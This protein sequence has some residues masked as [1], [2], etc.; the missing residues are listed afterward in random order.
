MSG[1]HS[2]TN[3]S[4]STEIPWTTASCQSDSHSCACECRDD[5]TCVFYD[6]R[7]MTCVLYSSPFSNFSSII[8]DASETGNEEGIMMKR[9]SEQNLFADTN[10]D[11]GLM[12][13]VDEGSSTYDIR[14]P[15]GHRITAIH[16]CASGH[17]RLTG[18]FAGFDMFFSDGTQQSALGCYLRQNPFPEINFDN[19][20]IIVKL[21]VYY[22]RNNGW[23]ALLI[24]AIQFYTTRRVLG[25][26]GLTAEANVISFVGYNLQGLYGN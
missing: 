12:L 17:S 26:F 19:D 5:S 24:Q 11:S 10:C 14:A 21:D 1:Y 2:L 20:E 9:G 23:D 13:P 3:G 25:P 16:L 6:V 22:G 15:T 18:L 4:A 8:L 7:N